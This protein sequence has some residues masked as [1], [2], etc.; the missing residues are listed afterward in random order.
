MEIPKFRS[1][2]EE[3]EFWSSH[4]ALDFLGQGEEVQIDAS[5]AKEA[6]RKRDTQLISLRVSKHVLAATKRRA[7]LL[8][9]PY[10]ALIQIWLAERLEE[11]AR[12]AVAARSGR[13]AARS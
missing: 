6:A 3:E 11:E 10:Q 5:V 12:R 9:V 7:A 4:S 2:E 13:S 8:G 1:L